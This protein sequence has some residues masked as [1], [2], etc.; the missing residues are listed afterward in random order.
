MSQTP[1]GERV[2][3]AKVARACCCAD[4]QVSNPSRGTCAF[5]PIGVYVMNRRY[6]VSNPS[7]GTCAFGLITQAAGAPDSVASQTP[8]GE[9][10]PSA[11]RFR[12]GQVHGPLRLKPLSGNVC[13]RP[14][15][16]QA[17][18]FSFGSS[19][20][21]LGERVPSAK[22]MEERQ[23]RRKWK[24]QTPLGERVPSADL[25]RAVDAALEG[26]SQTPL[27]ERVPSA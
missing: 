10:V 19:Q 27:G 9:R 2:P 14:G 3:S 7:R 22:K 24:S 11:G 17:Q 26:E 12:G 13:L 5:G 18:G 6:E 23:W 4:R 15:I 25:E 20:T 8:L 1:L 16:I 21:P